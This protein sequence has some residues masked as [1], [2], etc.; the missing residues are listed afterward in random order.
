[1]L[2]TIDNP[3]SP[4]YDWDRWYQFDTSHGYNSSSLLARF[5]FVSEELSSKDQEL[6]VEQAIDDIIELNPLGIHIKVTKS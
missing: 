5:A 3:Y 6:A 1:M 2:S 4:Y